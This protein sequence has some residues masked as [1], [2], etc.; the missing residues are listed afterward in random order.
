MLP[1][2]IGHL[3][4]SELAMTIFDIQIRGVYSV[5]SQDA[6]FLYPRQMSLAQALDLYG[7]PAIKLG[8]DASLCPLDVKKLKEQEKFINENTH[9]AFLLYPERGMYL[10]VEED[11]TIIDIVFRAKCF[12]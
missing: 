4:L 8:V 12:Y 10:H 7:K 2:S 5:A 11:K 1:V 6:T 3:S 9:L